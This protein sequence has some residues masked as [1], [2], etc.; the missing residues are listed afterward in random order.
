MPTCTYFL[1]NV[2]SNAPN[3]IPACFVHFDNNRSNYGAK[4]FKISYYTY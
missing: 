1:F 2:G 3:I 4:T